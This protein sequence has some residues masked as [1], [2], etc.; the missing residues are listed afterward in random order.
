MTTASRIGAISSEIGSETSIAA[1]RR[2]NEL[3]PI[4]A[5]N[6]PGTRTINAPSA[7]SGAASAGAAPANVANSCTTPSQPSP[8]PKANKT[9]PE[10]HPRMGRTIQGNPS[11]PGKLSPFETPVGAQPPIGS[12][13]G[14]AASRASI[15]ARPR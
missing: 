1:G 4:P 10:T 8:A 11:R 7:E 3:A 2:G 13:G 15:S 5:N 14:S 12:A 6:A 9:I